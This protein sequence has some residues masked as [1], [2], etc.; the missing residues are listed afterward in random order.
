MVWSFKAFHFLPLP[1][2]RSFLHES[3]AQQLRPQRL[4]SE[5]SWCL[6]IKW[7]GYC[8]D[9]DQDIGYRCPGPEQK[10]PCPVRIASP[11]CWCCFSLACKCPY[12]SPNTIRIHARKVLI[13][14]AGLG[15]EGKAILTVH[16]S[17]IACFNL[18]GD[19]FTLVVILSSGCSIHFIFYLLFR[20]TML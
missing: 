7:H 17:R 11:G 1:A 18:F 10:L 13:W 2:C 9:H 14:G 19:S 5:A 15:V 3:S 6:G 8:M 16:Y 12:T 20:N 4:S